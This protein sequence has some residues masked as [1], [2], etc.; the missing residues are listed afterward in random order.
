MRH[1]MAHAVVAGAEDPQVDRVRPAP[2]DE[3]G[4]AE[5]GA[6]LRLWDR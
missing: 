6:T 3:D 1:G 4:E 5:L 2:L